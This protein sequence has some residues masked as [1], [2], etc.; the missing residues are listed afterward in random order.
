M[1]AW[2]D[3][4]KFSE[5][6]K[7]ESPSVSRAGCGGGVLIGD[8]HRQNEPVCNPS[9]PWGATINSPKAIIHAAMDDESNILLFAMDRI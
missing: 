8:E 9:R 2:R 3:C 1:K 6:E 4:G 5:K 7:T